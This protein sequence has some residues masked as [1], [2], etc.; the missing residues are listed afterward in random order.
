MTTISTYQNNSVNYPYMLAIRHI[1]QGC[2]KMQM[3]TAIHYSFENIRSGN[4]TTKTEM[5]AMERCTADH[6][7]FIPHLRDKFNLLGANAWWCFP[8][9]R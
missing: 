1:E 7:S 8:L 2:F 9:N 5:I 3:P 6:F 4:T